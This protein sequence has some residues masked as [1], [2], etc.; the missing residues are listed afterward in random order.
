[1]ICVIA[2]FFLE[3]GTEAV[4]GS[5]TFCRVASPFI[6]SLRPTSSFQDVLSHE[7]T[8]SLGCSAFSRSPRILLTTLPSLL[9]CLLLKVEY[10]RRKAGMGAMSA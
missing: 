4:T 3:Q 2:L 10:L 9:F 5:K 7:D 6:G 1:M 8:C